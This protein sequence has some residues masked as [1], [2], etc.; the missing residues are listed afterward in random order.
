MTS[1]TTCSQ[2]TARRAQHVFELETRIQEARE[3]WT[4]PRV[5]TD[6]PCSALIPG[7]DSPDD[8]TRSPAAGRRKVPSSRRSSVDQHPAAAVARSPA[9]EVGRIQTEEASAALA[10]GG[11]GLPVPGAAAALARSALPAR[12][13]GAREPRAAVG[14][15]GAHRALRLAGVRRLAGPGVHSTIGS[16]AALRAALV[17]EGARS[18]VGLANSRVR[19]PR[20]RR[21][22]VAARRGHLADGTAGLG[23]P[24]SGA[25]AAL[26]SAGARR[27]DRSAAGDRAD[28]LPAG[29]WDARGSTAALI[30]ELALI[31]GGDAAAVLSGVAG[32]ALAR[33]AAEAPRDA[34]AVE[35]ADV[36]AGADL[37]AG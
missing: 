24:T 22:P 11:A 32:G 17:P 30:L 6:L 37:P 10:C 23:R 21:P 9:V 19:A 18:S 1:S 12:G 36:G 5:E 27:A 33:G 35:L 3:S 14:G 16:D 26:G 29:S 20:V 8:R 34:R 13:D 25:R 2:P 4:S 31:A 15:A 28:Q 7:V